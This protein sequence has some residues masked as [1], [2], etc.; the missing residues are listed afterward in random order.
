MLRSFGICLHLLDVPVLSAD[1]V[2]KRVGAKAVD[3][4]HAGSGLDQ[5]FHYLCVS[6]CCCLVGEQAASCRI[7]WVLRQS[8]VV[9]GLMV[10]CMYC[11]VGI[12][13]ADDVVRTLDW[14]R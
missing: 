6:L 2:L 9:S 11:G 7:S 1:S 4:R 12:R 3:R 8:S 14:T 13:Y 5:E 10:W